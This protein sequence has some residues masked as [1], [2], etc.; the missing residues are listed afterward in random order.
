VVVSYVNFAS[1]KINGVYLINGL[2]SVVL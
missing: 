2:Y 1:F